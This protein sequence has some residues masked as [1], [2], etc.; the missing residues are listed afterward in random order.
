MARAT[1][2][3][4][5]HP[6]GPLTHVPRARTRT[7]RISPPTRSAT[8]APWASG[9]A[10]AGQTRQTAPARRG[11]TARCGRLLRR[12]TLVPRER[13]LTRYRY[14]RRPSAN[15]ARL[16]EGRSQLC[17]AW[18]HESYFLLFSSFGRLLLRQRVRSVIV[19]ITASCALEYSCCGA[20]RSWV[21]LL[22]CLVCFSPLS[23]HVIIVLSFDP[24]QVLLPGSFD[25]DRTVPGGNLQP[26]Q[27]HRGQ[28]GMLYAWYSRT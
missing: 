6:P 16:G 15:S 17:F 3:N 1:G 7:A 11:T 8:P 22:A 19:D 14:S 21:Y 13:F 10:G 24:S 2:A 4:R 5:K 28:S 25:R 18:T 27:P 26:L 20:H 12:I 9:A 23:I